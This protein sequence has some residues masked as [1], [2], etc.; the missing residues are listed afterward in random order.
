MLKL[1]GKRGL[2]LTLNRVGL[3]KRCPTHSKL[4][5]NG[6]ENVAK[7]FTFKHPQTWMFWAKQHQIQD[8]ST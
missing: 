2:K 7:N 4:V 1:W 8:F 3:G 5:A 6:H